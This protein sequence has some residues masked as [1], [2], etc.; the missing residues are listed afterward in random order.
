MENFGE[1]V[2]KCRE[3]RCYKLREFAEIIEISPYYLSMIENGKKKNPK[4]QIIGRIYKAL[5]L[6]KSEMEKLLY[7][8]AKANDTVCSDIVDYIM[9]NENIIRAIR[10]ERDKQGSS[11]NW[12]D[13]IN[14]ICTE[15]K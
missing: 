6:T 9:E 3:S 8:Y 15:E 4:I 5:K 13:F 12:N 7:L 1:Y 10:Y 11:P 14:K 2:Q